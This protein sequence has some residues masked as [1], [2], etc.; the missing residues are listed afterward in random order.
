MPGPDSK[1]LENFQDKVIWITGASSGIGE[2][3]AHRF[4]A[5]GARVVLSARRRHGWDRSR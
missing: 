1:E 4:A 3:L 2:A 5:T